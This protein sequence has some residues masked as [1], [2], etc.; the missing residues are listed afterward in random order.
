M[1][2]ATVWRTESKEGARVRNQ[3]RGDGSLDQDDGS[4][5][6]FYIWRQDFTDSLMDCSKCRRKQTPGFLASTTG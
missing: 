6:G 3:G 2:L 5:D 1:I 4:R